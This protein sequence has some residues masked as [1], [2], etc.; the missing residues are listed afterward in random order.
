[1]SLSNEDSLRLNV[2]TAQPVKAIRI[3]ESG[4]TLTALTELGEAR[5]D[6]APNTRHEAYLREVRDFLSEKYLGMPGGYPRHLERWTRMGVTHHSLDKM[7]LLGE[8]E[9]IVSLACSRAIDAELAT[10]AWWACQSPE[11]ARNLL[12]SRQVVESELGPV[13]AEFLLEF[14][15][16]EERPLDVVDSVKQC[17]QEGLITHRE[18]DKLWERARR[19]NPYF[20]GFLLAGP[21]AIPMR[22]TRHPDYP[23]IE[24]SLAT[25][26][27]KNNPYARTY[28]HFLSEAGRKWLISLN[29]A[30]KKPGEPDVVTAL[31]IAIEQYIGLDIGEKRGVRTIDLIQENARAWSSL[32][33]APEQLRAIFPKLG[34]TQREQLTSLLILAQLGEHTLD[35]VFGGRDATGT[36]MRKHLK[37]FTKLI[38]STSNVLLS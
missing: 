4:M 9:A 28:L 3:N 18:R 20:V 25:E 32:E 19:R 33:A 16:F 35:E 8:Q 30:L 24:K 12:K 23:E 31:F 22:E 26:L 7:L 36:V 29:L 14:L 38:Q 6:L 10:Y 21:Q 1:M 37:P 13:L 15:P 17:L 27:E 11:I 5:I 34:E 2:L